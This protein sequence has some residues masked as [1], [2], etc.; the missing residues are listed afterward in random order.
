[1][2]CRASSMPNPSRSNFTSPAAAQASLSHWST[3]RSFIR[4]HSTGT[5]AAMG[6]S[7]ITMPP[8]VN[9]QV[10]RL[11]EELPRQLFHLRR[12]LT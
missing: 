9:P 7:Q 8:R 12:R 4:A 2:W 10:T 3:E 1:M 5:T 6:R 11:A